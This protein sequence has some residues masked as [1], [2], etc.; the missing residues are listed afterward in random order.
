VSPMSFGMPEFKTGFTA[1]LDESALVGMSWM[2]SPMVLGGSSDGL[3]SGSHSGHDGAL[4]KRY[5]DKMF[6]PTALFGSLT[7]KR[8]DKE[9]GARARASLTDSPAEKKPRHESIGGDDSMYSS[10]QAGVE[11]SAGSSE[12]RSCITG[13]GMKQSSVMDMD[14]LLASSGTETTADSSTRL[15]CLLSPHSK[16][17]DSFVAPHQ[18]L[19]ASSPMMLLGPTGAT[20]I[21]QKSFG[22]GLSYTPSPNTLGA[23][24]NSNGT[25]PTFSGASGGVAGTPGNFFSKLSS[26]HMH[27]ASPSPQ[28]LQS[29]FENVVTSSPGMPLLRPQQ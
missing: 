10:S 6:S 29:F 25:L 15:V 26:S 2:Q 20:P 21:G 8:S 14:S 7:P 1:G 4:V 22:L 28:T 23:I 12:Q 24:S 3:G 27:G 18:I 17:R 16:G 5:D 19:D 13:N 11:D 9:S